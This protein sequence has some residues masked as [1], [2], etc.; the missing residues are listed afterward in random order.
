MKVS[1]H[2]DESL[3]IN[4]ILNSFI[5]IRTGFL[6][7]LLL[8]SDSHSYSLRLLLLLVVVVIRSEPR[9]FINRS[10]SLIHYSDGTFHNSLVYTFKFVA[11]V[12]SE[13]RQ[14]T[15]KRIFEVSVLNLNQ[16]NQ[17]SSYFSSGSVRLAIENG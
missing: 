6:L 15:I 2:E 14:C 1:L 8:L 11:S 10:V 13:L 4:V 9:C 17:S 12:G 7:L 5:M 3:K 16:M